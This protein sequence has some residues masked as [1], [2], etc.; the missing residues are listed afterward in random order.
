[1]P[2]IHSRTTAK[3][4]LEDFEGEKLD[5]WVTGFGTGGTLKGVARVLQK[6]R[7]ETKVVVCEPDDAPMLSSGIAQQ[8]KCRWIASR[9]PPLVEAAPH[10]GMESGFHCETDGRCRQSE[11][12]QRGDP[13]CECRCNEVQ[14]GTCAEGGDLRRDHLGCDIR[15]GPEGSSE[16]PKGS[17]ILCMLP[18]TGERY[19]STP[20]FGDISSI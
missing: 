3:E 14:P 12:D 5:Y 1:M 15:R 8:A 13:H 17:T 16:A 9:G 20:L 4:I 11:G 7:P 18:D 6:E 19:F 2:T 10:P